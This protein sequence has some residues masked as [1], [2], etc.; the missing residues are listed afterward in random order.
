MD[1]RNPCRIENRIIPARIGYETCGAWRQS[2]SRL[3][4]GLSGTLAE[5]SLLLLLLSKDQG[6]LDAGVICSASAGASIEGFI[7]K[8]VVVAHQSQP[9]A[10]ARCGLPG[11][12][13][14]PLCANGSALSTSE[15]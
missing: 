4:S 5:V 13:A 9:P 2:F 8:H 12:T 6:K 15:I 3:R 11:A 10:G 14:E 7:T 1:S